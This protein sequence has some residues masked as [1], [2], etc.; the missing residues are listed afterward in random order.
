ML[1]LKIYFS[2]FFQKKAKEKAAEEEPVPEVVNE[3]TEP[4]TVSQQCKKYLICL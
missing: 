3:L 1:T 2:N 4:I